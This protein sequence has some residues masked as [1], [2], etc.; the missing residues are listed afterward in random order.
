MP[1]THLSL[2]MCG[3]DVGEEAEHLG[4]DDRWEGVIKQQLHQFLH[5]LN[6]CVTLSKN[7]S[8]INIYYFQTPLRIPHLMGYKIFETTVSTYGNW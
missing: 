3:D 1:H 7:I 8:H 4:G 5:H 2:Y 6:L